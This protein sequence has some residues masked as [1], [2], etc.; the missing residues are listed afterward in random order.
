MRFQRGFEN[1]FERVRGSYQFLLTRIVFSRKVFVPAFLL[2]CLCAFL[3]LPF[4]GQDFF[5]NTDSGE[6]ILHVRGRTGMRIEETARLADLVEASIRSKIPGKELN[7]ILDNLGLP[8]SPMNT[9][10]STSGII[11]ASDGDI[12]VTSE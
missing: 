9:M 1:I 2:V 7:N 11:G 10:H 4:L 8:Y 6:F 12:M 3:L 5:P